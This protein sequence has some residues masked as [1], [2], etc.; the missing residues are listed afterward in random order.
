MKI[1]NLRIWNTRPSLQATSLTKQLEHLGAKVIELPLLSIQPVAFKI[2]KLTDFS[3][4]IFISPNA[5][6]YFFKHF[7]AKE[8][9]PQVPIIALGL[10]TA[11]T[12]QLYQIHVTTIPSQFNSEGILQL[13]CL[14]KI[15]KHAILIVKGL[16]G[17]EEIEEKLVQRGAIVHPLIVYQRIQTNVQYALND[18]YQRDAIDMIIITSQEA[19]DSLFA[20]LD[21]KQKIWLSQKIFLVISPRIKLAATHYGI[22]TILV[23]EIQKIMDTIEAIYENGPSTSPPTH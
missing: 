15:K 11:Q 22:K 10:G 19:L 8:W 3:Y 1:N 18:L 20:Q 9:P 23:A 5:V 6:H 4:A 13:D 7:P 16:K 2:P 14:Q 17:L 12:L 21:T